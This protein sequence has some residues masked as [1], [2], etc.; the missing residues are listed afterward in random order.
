[1]G[2]CSL[3]AK[4]F[5]TSIAISPL[6]SSTDPTVGSLPPSSLITE[7]I[8][9]PTIPP[10]SSF[11]SSRNGR[12]AIGFWIYPRTFPI[13]SETATT[14]PASPIDSTVSVSVFC[15]S[16]RVLPI[17]EVAVSKRPRRAV[18]VGAVEWILTASFTISVEFITNA[19]ALPSEV[20]ALSILANFL[21][22]YNL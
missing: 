16:L 9:P 8:P 22:P 2:T 15:S 20:N 6:T 21:S 7:S 5:A 3:T 18:A 14:L 13:E 12:S 11:P 4:Y 19:R 1:M 17:S 10:T